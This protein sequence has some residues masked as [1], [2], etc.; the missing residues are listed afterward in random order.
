M[1]PRDRRGGIGAL[2]AGALLC[3]IGL[4]FLLGLS[5]EAGVSPASAA[6]FELFRERPVGVET[7]PW[8]GVAFLAT[9]LLLAAVGA[10]MLRAR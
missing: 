1:D 7:S 9:G 2:V 4:T 10:S 3:G 8:L 6:F 5:A